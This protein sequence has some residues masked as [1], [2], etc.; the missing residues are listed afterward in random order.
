MPSE[1]PESDTEP[2]EERPRKDQQRPNPISLP[3]T[4]RW[5]R[6]SI[7]DSGWVG[8]TVWDMARM[9]GGVVFVVGL[10]FF[11]TG[12]TS[13]FV[14]VTSGSMEPNINTG[15][16]VLS[17]KYQPENPPPLAKH[18]EIITAK[19]SRETPGSHVEFGKHGDVIVFTSEMTETPIIHRAHFWVEEN[20]NW[21]EQA[22]PEY[23]NG[24][25]SCEEVLSCP[26][27]N[28]GYIT[29]GD[30][31]EVYDQV[32]EGYQPVKKENVVAVAQYRIGYIG[33]FAFGLDTLTP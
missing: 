6:A 24:V 25:D 1:S 13:P 32:K 15:D 11:L 10:V 20:E 26:A 2:Q 31:N 23:L 22:D 21:V 30:S 19:Q 3:A 7:I 28:A 12:L 5:I 18:A 17:T 33:W 9:V 8:R 29:K 16:A 4:Y 27:P 14:A